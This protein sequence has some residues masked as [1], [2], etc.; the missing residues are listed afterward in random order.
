MRPSLLDFL[1]VVW[2]KWLKKIKEPQIGK[3]SNKDERRLLAAP[4]RGLAK[5]VPLLR[6][7]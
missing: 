4:W 6:V 5:P 3:D 7:G 2:F 1:V